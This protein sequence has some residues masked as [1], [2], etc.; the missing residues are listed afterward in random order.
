VISA[1]CQYAPIV[2][3]AA[4]PIRL[5]VAEDVLLVREGITH[6]LETYDDLELVAPVADP[7]ALRSAIDE[8][9]PDVVLTDIRMPP[10]FQR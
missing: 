2:A 5:A 1:A 9:R 7:E 3:D 10:N 4:Q 8:H 6:A